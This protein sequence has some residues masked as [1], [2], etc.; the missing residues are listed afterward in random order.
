MKQLNRSYTVQE[1]ADHAHGRVIGDGTM[2]ISALVALESPRTGGVTFLRS[3]SHVALARTLQDLPAM[4]L[5][6]DE[7]LLSP[8]LPATQCA[9]IVVPNAHKAFIATVSLFFEPYP[10]TLSAHPTA[11]IAPTAKIGERVSIGAACVI[12]DGCSIGDDSVLDAHVVLYP[13]VSLGKGVRL[14]SGVAVREGCTIGDRSIIHNN[15]VI[16]ADGFGYVSD[17]KTGISKVPQVGIVEVG[18]D[19]EI[20]ANTTI[21]R[22]TVGATVIGAHTKIDNQVQIGHNVVIGS[23]CII[24]AQAGV[25][26]ST[27]IGAG[28]VLGGGAGVADH[29]RVVSGVRVGGHGAVLT[30]LEEPGDYL[31]FPAVKAMQYRRQQV[32]LRRLVDS[33]S[34]KN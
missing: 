10:T 16:G 28:V 5:F 32:T 30:S 17:P 9:L 23:H 27:E 13:D 11:V 22:G 24:C 2:S 26:G 34:H 3:K 31:G 1:I 33:K 7:S 18:S 25:A 20:G 14:Y 21:D 29:V 19:V 6:V 12:G 4:A 15:A 8:E